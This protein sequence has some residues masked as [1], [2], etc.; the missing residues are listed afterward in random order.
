MGI[1][2]PAIGKKKLLT[3]ARR[4]RRGNFEDFRYEYPVG[5]SFSQ[6]PTTNHQQYRFL[7]ANSACSALN[8]FNEN[9]MRP[10][11][12]DAFPTRAYQSGLSAAGL[13]NP[14]TLTSTPS[15]N[16]S[17]RFRLRDGHCPLPSSRQREDGL[18]RQ[19]SAH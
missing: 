5:L 12:H 1:I 3:A 9:N 16:Q 15:R 13:S 11:T 19:S 6:R 14:R 18:Q 4:D 17:R 8:V 10:A 2:L 7:S